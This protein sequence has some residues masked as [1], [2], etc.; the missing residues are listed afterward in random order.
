MPRGV[1]ESAPGHTA[2]KWQRLGWSMASLLEFEHS[3]AT[4]LRDLGLGTDSL[5]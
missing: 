1:K 5:C 2:T 3:P 4:R